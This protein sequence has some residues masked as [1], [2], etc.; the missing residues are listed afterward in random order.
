MYFTTNIQLDT[1]LWRFHVLNV[2]VHPFLSILMPL[3]LFGQVW[4]LG[5]IIT[6]CLI[7]LLLIILPLLNMFSHP[8]RN[9]FKRQSGSHIHPSAR[10]TQWILATLKLRSNLTWYMRLFIIWPLPVSPVYHS[11]NVVPIMLNYLPF[12]SVLYFN[13]GPSQIAASL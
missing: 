5:W 9:S 1:K 6:P 12:S 13:Y 11:P 4:Y 10:V 7:Y 8:Q 2:L 3:I